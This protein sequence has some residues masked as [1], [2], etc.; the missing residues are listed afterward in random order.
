M[1]FSAELEPAFWV[2]PIIGPWL[3]RHKIT[4]ELLE[5]ATYMEMAVIG[6]LQQ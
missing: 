1:H 2:P 3:F 5:S 6:Q 4:S